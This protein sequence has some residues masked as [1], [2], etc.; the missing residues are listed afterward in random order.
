LRF[1]FFVLSV[2]YVSRA[3]RSSFFLLFIHHACFA[4]PLHLFDFDPRRSVGVEAI[5][6]L[7]KRRGQF[8][9]IMIETNGLANP[10]QKKRMRTHLACYCWVFIVVITESQFFRMLVVIV[11]VVYL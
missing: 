10:G 3:S 2:I 8:D 1:S 11:M 5:E 7:M 4:A 9:Y 6:S